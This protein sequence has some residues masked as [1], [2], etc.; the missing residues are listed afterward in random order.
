MP[1]VRSLLLDD[2]V[3]EERLVSAPPC[4]PGKSSARE[5]ALR[6]HRRPG[7]RHQCRPGPAATHGLTRPYTDQKLLKSIP[8]H[9]PA[10]RGLRSS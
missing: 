9:P 7:A 10:I 3:E 2:P 1:D 4:E 6:A 8:W 5:A